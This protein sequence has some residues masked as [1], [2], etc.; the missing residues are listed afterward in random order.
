MLAY[1]ATLLITLPNE[2]QR[3][4][5]DPAEAELCLEELGPETEAEQMHTPQRTQTPGKQP[6]I[7]RQSY[8]TPK[9]QSQNCR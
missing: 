2:D 5:Q 3:Q 7:N 6:R 1:P 9:R 4:F 8:Y